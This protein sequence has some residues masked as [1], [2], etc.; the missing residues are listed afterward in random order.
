MQ[1][2]DRPDTVFTTARMV[3]VAWAWCLIWPVMLGAHLFDQVRAGWTDG[4]DRPFGEDFINFWS[5][6]RLA[7]TRR[8][9]SIYDFTAFHDFQVGV[10]GH[11]IDLYHYSYPPVAMVLT[12]PLGLLPYPVAWLAWQMLGW[13][14]FAT[15]LRRLSPRH[16][17]LAALAWPAVMI[18]ALG[19]QIGCWIAAIIAWGLLLLPRRPVAAGLLLS[20]LVI[21][22]QLAW[23]VPLA[24][25]AGRE[26]R[27]LAAATIGG[28]AL[29]GITTLCFGVAIWPDYLD[30]AQTLKQFIL[31]DGTG[32]WHRMISVFVL[33]RHLGA[34]LVLAYGAQALASLATAWI[35]L[36]AWYRGSP[37]RMHFLI[38][39]MLVGSIYVSD[40]DCVM[41]AFPAVALWRHATTNGRLVIVLTA[42]IPLV[43]A[44]L[45]VATGVAVGTLMLWPILAVLHGLDREA[46]AL[47]PVL[48]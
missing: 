4:V 18:N 3:R 26:W 1:E 5:A 7:I 29:L 19:G 20:L 32:T 17:Q 23:L 22:P 35:V 37:L 30:Q 28:I 38:V 15:A 12:A 33:V 16:W 6:A 31:E 14:A 13:L 27:A 47:R 40:Y 34:P 10:V 46:P 44:A 24:L 8:V 9:T 45:A 11:A 39:G 42:S 41:L 21:K 2:I 43:A 25:L 36:A 48:A